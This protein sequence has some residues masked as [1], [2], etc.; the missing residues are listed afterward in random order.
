MP[1]RRATACAVVR[2]SPVSMTTRMP[3]AASAASAS[4]VVALTG[5]AMA[6]TP[7]A[8]PSTAD[9]DRG[10]A[11]AAQALGLSVER[12]WSSMLSSARNLALPSATRSPLDHADHALAGRRIEAAHRRQARCLRS[13]AAS[14]IA[15]ASGCSLAR[16][17]LAASRSTS[18]SSKPAAPGRRPRPS[19]CLRSACRSCRSPA[20]RPSPSAP[21]PRRS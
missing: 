18:S 21:A 11:V 4:G 20:C 8:L 5:S 13:A 10:G 19:A 6:M 1:S 7:A 3:S 15:A 14:T 2:L 17:T 16:S 9:E 12:R